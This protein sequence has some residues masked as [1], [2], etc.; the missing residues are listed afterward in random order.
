L[1]IAVEKGSD[2]FETEI[3]LNGITRD[4]NVAIEKIPYNDNYALLTYIFDMTEV[5]EREIELMRSRQLNE[6][7]LAK[8]NISVRATKI[9]LWDLDVIKDDPMDPDNTF[10][11]SDEFRYMLGFYNE[12][13]FSN[14]FSNWIGLLHPEDKPRTLDSFEKHLQDTSGNT[15]YDIE[16]RLLK[17]NGEYGYFHASGEAIRDENGKPVRI[18]GAMMDIT[19]TKT[20][21]FDTEKQRVA[22]EA[23]NRAKSA[24]LSTMSH[25]IRTPMNAILGITEI[26]LQNEAHSPDVID[27]L[28]KIYNSGDL[29]LGII[30]DILDMSKIEAGKL[31]LFIAEYEMAS[32]ISDTAQ[33]N[34][35]RIGSKS[36]EFEICIDENL[37]SILMGD[38]LRVKQVLNN[39]LSNAFKYSF[40]GCVKLSVDK[41][42][43]DDPTDENI[44]L[45]FTVCD[46]GQGMSKEQIDK[47]FDEY[48]RFNLEANRSTEGTGLGMSITQNLISMMDGRISVESEPN[49]GT[50]F[51]VY[52]PQKKVGTKVLGPDV[53]QNLRQFRTKSL[54]RMKRVQ[55]TREYMP[56]GSVLIV[57][58]VETNI[59]VTQG[60][61]APY[62]INVD[63]AISGFE[64]IDKVQ[65]GNVY[66]I[67][68]MDHMMP[69]MDGIQATKIIR[70]L[71][72]TQPIVA[73]TA[74]AVTGQAEVFLSNGFD[75]FISK[76]ID[77]RQ[78]NATLNRLIRDK[79]SPEVIEAARLQA[80]VG[81]NI[82]EPDGKF[83]IDAHLASVFIHDASKSLA[84]LKA[85]NNLDDSLSEEELKTFTIQVH[86]IK[87]ALANIGKTEL[88]ALA[89]RLETSAREGNLEV[90]ASETGTF[91]DSLE[92]LIQE[93]HAKQAKDDDQTT[94]E[95]PQ[96]LRE[97]LKAIKSACEEYDEAAADN[98]LIELRKLKWSSPTRKLIASISEYLL[99]SDFDDAVSAIDNF[100]DDK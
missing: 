33:L 52:I 4:I 70:D 69:K 63:T 3:R 62:G 37:P 60:L 11:C 15:P 40:E 43:N 25:E 90:M 82:P 67:I 61:M 94:D 46:T 85:I 20:I 96:L 53:T 99:H 29:L 71:G 57:D 17:N 76:P 26:Q 72:Y 78:L 18:V 8:L 87:S 42:P 80:E 66:D 68:F 64:A 47:L 6:L 23:A 50:T 1:T 48:S 44:T 54:T 75:D 27:A 45:V 16:Y 56:Y 13:E 32:L 7:Q 86:G 100:C 35:M 12:N 95:Y 73:L 58:D 9:G 5:H 28:K 30:N 74:N 39:L 2:R 91:L 36:L 19:E 89:L 24:F 41:I 38:E 21:L 88:S 92:A 49:K 59:Y 98:V 51:Y 77:L 34:I 14:L 55:V 97:K 84:A 81:K 79:Q 83:E 22:A 31:E 10:S 93:L 65:A